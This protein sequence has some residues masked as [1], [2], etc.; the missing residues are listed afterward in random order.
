MQGFLAAELHREAGVSEGKCGL[1]ELQKFQ[2]YLTEYQIIVGSA[3][4]C[5]VIFKDDR[6]NY[7]QDKKTICLVKSEDLYD[8]LTSIPAFVNRSYFC[9]LCSRAYDHEDSA[10][11]NCIGQNCPAGLQIKGMCKNYAQWVPRNVECSD[12]H[13][14]FY[15]PDC[16]QHHKTTKLCGKYCKCLECRR[17]YQVDKRKPHKCYRETC[18]NCVE[19]TNL[20]EHKCYIQPLI[21]E[22]E[23]QE[24]QDEPSQD[25]EEK[26]SPLPPLMLF[27]DFECLL[28]DERK[29]VPD[30]IC[31]SSSE[32]EEI[33]YH[34]GLDC[35]EQFIRDMEDLIEVP[36]N[37]HERYIHIFFHNLERFDGLFV[38]EQ[39]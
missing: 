38:I 22:K 23:P 26:Q 33:Q 25:R 3:N 11:H 9:K 4:K 29:F 10:H 24:S 17:E 31:F 27:V 37:E 8:G 19:Y 7:V 6:Y 34:S 15:G 18:M 14:L 2:D 5:T 21:D 32:E 16:F 39:L 1:Q 12:C 13:C 36:E 35:V 30:L 28:D 20:L